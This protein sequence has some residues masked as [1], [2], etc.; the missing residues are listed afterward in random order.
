MAD[1]QFTAPG[2][3]V[4]ELEQTH[5][6]KP[7]TRYLS[8]A[9]PPALSRGFGEGTKRYGLLLDTLRLGVV[10]DFLY[11]QFRPVGAPEGAKGPPPKL[12]FMLITRLHPPAQPPSKR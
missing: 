7:A 1:V 12:L 10:N 11:N 3:G 9:F 8:E 6:S 5:F 2:P 4:W